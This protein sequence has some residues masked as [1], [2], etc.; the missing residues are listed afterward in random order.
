MPKTLVP[1]LLVFLAAGQVATPQLPA[2]QPPSNGAIAPN[3][4]AVAA[5]KQFA[6]AVRQKVI[7]ER[8]NAVSP[9][10]NLTADGPDATFFVYNDP[11]MNYSDCSGMLTEDFVANLRR[12]GFTQLICTDSGNNAK[13]SFDLTVLPKTRIY[14]EP[15]AMP[16]CC[17]RRCAIP[18]ASCWRPSISSRTRKLSQTSAISIAPR[19]AMTD[20]AV[21]YRYS[22]LARIRDGWMLGHRVRVGTMFIAAQRISSST[23]PVESNLL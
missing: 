22:P 7:K 11:G 6:E 5:R 16:K 9:G 17:N 12:Y 3:A 2:S 21:G 19:T 18:T 8:G 15:S 20:T 10:Y 14:N 1:L 23:S 4:A 13:F